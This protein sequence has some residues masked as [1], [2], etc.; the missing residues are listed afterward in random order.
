VLNNAEEVV[1]HEQDVN[2][3]VVEKSRSLNRSLGIASVV[4]MT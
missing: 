1:V 2:K 4:K 3:E